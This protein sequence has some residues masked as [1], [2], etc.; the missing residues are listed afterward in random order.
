MLCIKCCPRPSNFCWHNALTYKMQVICLRAA[1]NA[2]RENL[3]QYKNL[4]NKILDAFLIFSVCLR[5]LSFI[6]QLRQEMFKQCDSSTRYKND[7]CFSEVK[8]FY[9][10][11]WVVFVLTQKNAFS[12]RSD[13]EANRKTICSS[14]NWFLGFLKK[15]FI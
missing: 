6:I 10:K 8:T 12:Q 14:K 7:G 13:S 5:N 2:H 15:L 11:M 1:N 3:I 9:G 4:K